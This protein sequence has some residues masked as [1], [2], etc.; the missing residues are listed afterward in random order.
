MSR[1]WPVIVS[2]E[3]SHLI[4]ISDTNSSKGI[5]NTRCGRVVGYSC[6]S[7]LIRK[8]SPGLFLGTDWK[9]L[10]DSHD[11]E[12]TLCPRCGSQQDFEDAFLEY[13]AAQE[14][15]RLEYEAL[16]NRKA[17]MRHE[18]ALQRN[19]DFDRIVECRDISFKITPVESI[20]L[21]LLIIVDGREYTVE[22]AIDISHQVEKIIEGEL[23]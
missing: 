2:A 11:K 17:V 8:E 20:D 4:H 12:P 3:K 13:R 14:S 19:K 22:P 16:K 15:Q 6:I 10:I 21:D 18:L 7:L 5:V 9:W 1:K 23:Q